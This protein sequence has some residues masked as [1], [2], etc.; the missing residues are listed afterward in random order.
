M[1]RAQH[2]PGHPLQLLPPH[3]PQPKEVLHEALSSVGPS[4]CSRR[5]WRRSRSRSPSTALASKPGPS[6]DRVKAKEYSAR[7]RLRGSLRPRH[8]PRR[9]ARRARRQPRPPVARHHQGQ[10]NPHIDVGSGP[11]GV[12]T[13]PDGALYVTDRSAR[14]TRPSASPPRGKV[15]SYQ[16]P[17]RARFP[18]T[19]SPP[20]TARCGSP[21]PHGDQIGRITTDGEGHRVPHP[22]PPAPSPPTS[23]SGPTAR[24]GSLESEAATRSAASRPRAGLPSTSLD[25]VDGLP[26]PIVSRQGRV[27][28]SSAERNTNTIT[29]MN[30]GGAGD[31]SGVA[32]EREREPGQPRGDPPRFSTSRST[33]SAPSAR[34][35]WERRLRPPLART[36]SAPDAITV[37]PDGA[38]WYVSGNE[39]K[40][41]RLAIDC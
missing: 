24:C 28:S 5:R 33:P 21:S 30:T 13:G 6:H 18:R 9:R 31:K 14:S 41:G 20:P 32:A 22:R 2:Q 17:P 39:G 16:R 36:K 26:G 1:L 34:M 10:G 7:R 23:P 37:G 25:T 4:P 8:R 38:L 12:A 35:S 11:A 27:A 3:S 19:S 29:R 15:T 40:V